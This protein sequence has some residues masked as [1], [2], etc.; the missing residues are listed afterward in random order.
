LDLTGIKFTALWS[1][2]ER[3]DVN[4]SEVVVTGYDNTVRG[5]QT[6][7]LTYGAVNASIGVTVLKPVPVDPSAPSTISVYFTLKGAPVHGGNPPNGVPYLVKN[8][9]LETWIPR[10]RHTVDLNATVADAVKKAID[11][12]GITWDNPSGNYIKGLTRNGIYLAELTNGANSGWVYTLNGVYSLKGIGEQYLEDGDSIA[13]YYTDDWTQDEIREN[14]D[15]TG[16]WGGGS[17]SPDAADEEKTGGIPTETTEIKAEESLSDAAFAGGTAKVEAKAEDV[18]AAIETAKENN[19]AAVS[20]TVKG[21]EN[22]KTADVVLPKASAKEIADSGLELVVKSPVG[23]VS[24]G[25]DAL[26]NIAAKQGDML[27]VILSD[28]GKTEALPADKNN[29]FTLTVKVGDTALTD[30]GGTV[31]VALPYAKTADEDA[32][33]LTVYKLDADGTYTEVKDAKYDEKAGKA[34]FATSETGSYVVSEWISPF[35]DIAKGDWYYKSVR[36][37]YAKGIMNGTGEGSYA[38]QATLTRAMLVTIL[39]RE[40]GQ[41][42]EGGDTWYARA[43]EWGVASGLTDGTNPTGEI[44][45]EQFAVMLWRQAGSPRPGGGFGTYGDADEVSAWAEEAMA[46]A[47]ETGLLTGRTK[48]TLAPKGTATRAEAATILQRYIENIAS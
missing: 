15:P 39:A 4:P 22:I 29:A 12:A 36:Y 48:T 1:N 16:E 10:A 28:A 41:S 19:T 42:T 33:L 18:K 40:A 14:V 27:E 38:P 11:E 5:K 25:K 13:F 17:T 7:T 30:L 20:V 26:T 46:W 8:N 35:E 2:G 3:T 31:A 37:A 43:L 23:D 32:E 45:R 24:L 9:N 47:V 6:V 21:D 44:T 34:T